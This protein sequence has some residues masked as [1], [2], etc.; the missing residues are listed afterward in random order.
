MKLVVLV[1]ALIIVM[2]VQSYIVPPSSKTIET[3][4]DS[5]VTL[6]D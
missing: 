4:Y 5:T 3:I 2:I 1:I 6:V